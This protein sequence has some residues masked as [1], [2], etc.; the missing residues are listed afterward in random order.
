[1]NFFLLDYDWS[2]REYSTWTESRWATDAFRVRAFLK[3]SPEME[4]CVEQPLLV[5][6]HNIELCVCC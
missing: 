2:S 1:M 3:P 4:V 5:F 6:M